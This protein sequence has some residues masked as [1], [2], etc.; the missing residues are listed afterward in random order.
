MTSGGVLPM[1]K[2]MVT[3]RRMTGEA[4]PHEYTATLRVFSTTLSCD[5]LI[6]QL[7]EPTKSYEVGDPVSSRTP[8]GPKREQNM[9]AL[10]SPN[11]RDSMEM[12]L[13]ALVDYVERNQKA[14]DSVRQDCE[15]DIFCGMFSGTEAQGGFTLDTEQIR[16]LAD[17]QLEV[18][19]DLY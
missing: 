3:L 14:F 6:R 2:E 10:D 19:F 15:M 17:L 1:R 13:T 7:G 5:E 8:A 4:E 16:R 18:T 11:D 9:W 12:H